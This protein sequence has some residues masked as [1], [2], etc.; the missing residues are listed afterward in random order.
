MAIP[1]ERVRQEAARRFGVQTF[2]PGQ[3]EL[4]EAALSGEDALGILP[5]GGG[6][7]LT[8]QIPAVL[9][10]RAVVVVSPLLSL[11]EDQRSKAEAAQ[12]EVAKIDSTMT[13]R[14]SRD[15]VEEISQGSNDLIYVTP[16]RLENPEYLKILRQRGVSLLVVDEAHCVSQW[17]HDFRP[18]YLALRDAI[19]ALGRPPVLA[20][21]ATATPEVAADLLQQLGIPK[22]RVVSTG[23]ERPNLFFEVH[24]TVNRELKEATLRNI[25]RD[26]PG[27]GILYTSTVRKADELWS[28]LQRE[29]VEVG[30]YHGKLKTAER[31]ETQRRFMSNEIRLVVAT[32]AF[33]LGI[34][35][36]D[37][38]FVVHWSF[39]DSL[40]TYYQEAGRAGRDGKPSTAALLYRLEDKR[41][42]S[43]FLGGKYPKREDSLALWRAMTRLGEATVPQLAEQT[44]LSEKRVKVIA[45]QLVSAGAVERRGG[46]LV[47]V[48]GIRNLTAFLTQYETRHLTDRARLEAMMHYAQSPDCRR[49]LLRDYFHEERI[50]RGCEFCDNCRANSG[51]T[52]AAA[53][54]VAAHSHSTADAA[55]TA[56]SR[57][58][59]VKRR[60]RAAEDPDR[61]EREARSRNQ[62]KAATGDVRKTRGGEDRRAE[63]RRAQA[64]SQLAAK[65]ARDR[66]SKP[67]SDRR[68]PAER[69]T[70]KERARKSR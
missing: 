7:S 16:E 3:R 14:E 48:A 10:P 39:P 36:P 15:A 53:A 69:R 25:L 46:K 54:A 21:T 44:A 66:R 63:E 9:L 47:K 68:D 22:A 37:I 24:R 6:K 2:R 67:A 60:P 19:R 12:I 28:W 62:R 29:G 18:A 52:A 35:K 5:T 11:M 64:A 26:V 58:A 32:S 31:E 27:L 50:A 17:G 45:A 1:W 41:V 65:A 34:D 59:P 55:A 23:T 33:G 49:N 43:Y 57:S 30:R 61:G 8:Y 42:Q 38:R 13:A 40:E 56:R 20:V 51:S 4:I 70:V